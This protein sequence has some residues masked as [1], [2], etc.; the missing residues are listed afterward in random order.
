MS[1]A[2]PALV[3]VKSAEANQPRRPLVIICKQMAPVVRAKPLRF[4]VDHSLLDWHIKPNHG[5]FFPLRKINSQWLGGDSSQA[6]LFSN[7]PCND[8]TSCWSWSG[9]HCYLPPFSVEK[10]EEEAP[11]GKA[12]TGHSEIRLLSFFL[13]RRGVAIVKGGKG[14]RATAGKGP[15]MRIEHLAAFATFGIVHCFRSLHP[16]HSSSLLDT[17]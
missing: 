8:A 4:S 6:Y 7:T 5:D 16:S 11:C 15:V 12:Y 17:Q 13:F 10:R 14:G 2:V 9:Y 3:R 1:E